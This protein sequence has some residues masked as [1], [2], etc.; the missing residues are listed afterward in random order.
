[1]DTYF[2]INP[3][4]EAK[5]IKFTPLHLY[6]EAHEWWYYVLVTLGHVS[7]TSYLDITEKLMERFDR[8]DMELHFRELEQLKQVR[9]SNAYITK[10]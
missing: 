3:M 10:F 4:T 6:G 8:K 5:A 7:I 2:Q 9:T 1:L